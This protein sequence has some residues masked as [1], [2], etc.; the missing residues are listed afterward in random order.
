MVLWARALDTAAA[1][2][3]A[4]PQYHTLP[5][6]REQADLEDAWTAERKTIIPGLLH[7][8]GV[9]A[10]LVGAVLGGDESCTGTHC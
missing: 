4:A 1:S 8:Y 7:K 9:E 2:P 3:S 6:L 10:W 5:P